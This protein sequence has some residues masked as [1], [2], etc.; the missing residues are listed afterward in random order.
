MNSFRVLLCFCV[1]LS[2]LTLASAC[3]HRRGPE[4]SGCVRFAQL[5]HA[6]EQSVG[7]CVS[8]MKSGLSSVVFVTAIKCIEGA[9]TCDMAKDCVNR[10]VKEQ[11]KS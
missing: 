11:K 3:R 10:A 2:L 7:V 1:G 4:E 5:C 6:S 8:L 9:T